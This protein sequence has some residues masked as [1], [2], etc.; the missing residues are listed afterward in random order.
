[1]KTLISLIL[2]LL[3]TLPALAEP[4]GLFEYLLTLDG[5]EYKGQMSYPEDP[6][7]EMNKPM[8]MKVQKVSETEVRIPFKVGDD[9]S[10]TWI[11]TKSDEGV[12]L[13]HDHRHS[14]GTPDDLTN[15]GGLDNQA[16]LGNQLIFPAD[17][18]TIEMLPEAASNVWSFRL[19]PDKKN[20]YYYLERHKGP[21]FE[22]VFDLTK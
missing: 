20:F 2:T 12:L 14:D 18:E 7:H 3:L 1:M 22:T 8:L 5:K 17:E 21:R 13:K 15:Y 9:T 10:R 4:T 16:I 19:S 6:A 11:I